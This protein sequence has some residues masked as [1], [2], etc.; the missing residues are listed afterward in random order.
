M[1]NLDDSLKENLKKINNKRVKQSFE[2]VT[3]NGNCFKFKTYKLGS[4]YSFEC[5]RQSGV[6]GCF[7]FY[8]TSTFETKANLFWALESNILYLYEL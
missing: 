4:T 2:I 8:N 3:K 1:R 6:N 5:Y 7:E